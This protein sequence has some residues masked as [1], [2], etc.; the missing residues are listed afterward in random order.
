MLTLDDFIISPEDSL[1]QAMEQTT[2]NK[3]GALFVCDPE[4]RLLGVVSDGDVRRSLLDSALLTMQVKRIMNMDP[5]K[6]KDFEEAKAFLVKYSFVA[7]PVVDANG[8]LKESALLDQGKTVRLA[9]EAAPLPVVSK[10][11][12]ALAIIPARGGSK[13]IPRKNL[14]PVGGKPLLAWA[15]L[16]AKSSKQVAHT[17]IST[18][19]QEIAAMAKQYGADVPWLRP[20]ALAADHTS[21]LEV[22]LH[23]L[24]W[25][26]SNYKPAP[27][28]AVLLE[29]T[30][31]L[32]KSYHIDKALQMLAGSDADSVVS[33]CEVPH[34]FHPEEILAVEK[35]FVRPYVASRT[36]AAR[37]LRGNQEPVYVLN[38]LVYAFRIKSVLKNRELYG[39][40]CLPYVMEWDTYLDIDT[41]EDLK[42]ADAR[43]RQM[44]F[45][46]QD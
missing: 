18:D 11:L 28:F 44:N 19:D 46:S 6:A 22:V 12:S 27:E 36:M 23:A 34:T 4:M 10:T 2:Q 33:V 42:A 7:I 17:L 5:V 37:K 26:V 15:I 40:K 14:A 31:P 21:T 24:E 8:F 9:F 1:K 41:P 20:A 45:E 32:R 35:G 29:P 3:K 30:S 43:L 16:A 39:A 25:A 13:R 38:G